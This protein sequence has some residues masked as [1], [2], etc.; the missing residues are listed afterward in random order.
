MEPSR[1]EEGEFFAAI[2]TSA[3]RA[4]LIGR[5]ALIALGFP[6]LTRDYDFW[7]HGD[8]IVRRSWNPWPGSRNDTQR[9]ASGLRPP[10]GPTNSGRRACRMQT[11]LQADKSQLTR[12]VP[13]PAD[14]KSRCG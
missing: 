14:I 4:I 1:F 12:P 10:A 6:L 7:I 5:R 9:R 8:D 13:L 3:T 2:T 11:S